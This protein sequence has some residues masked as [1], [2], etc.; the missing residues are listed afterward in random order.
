VTIASKT[1][2]QML[3]DA[4]EATDVD[5]DTFVRLAWSAYLEARP[6]MKERLEEAHLRAQL[7]AMRQAGHMPQ[8]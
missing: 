1:W 5:V 4:A 6:G 8:A 3:D 7:E 2:E